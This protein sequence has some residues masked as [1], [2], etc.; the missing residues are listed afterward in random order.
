MPGIVF[1]TA[2]LYGLADA[3]RSRLLME[4]AWR[5]GFRRFDT[6]PSY[7]GGRSEP[8]LGEFL[9]G[10]DGVEVVSTKVGLA[11]AVGSRPGLRTV[12]NV[13]KATL[14]AAVTRRLRR[15]AQAG[16][17]GRFAPAEVSASVEE[18][19]RRLGGRIDR[20]LLHEVQP[21]EITPA[22][23]ETLTSLLRRGDVGAVGVAT[24]NAL[25]PA[26]L[27]AGGE[28]FTVAHVAV[29]PL[30]EPVQLPGSVTTRV[31]HGLLGNGGEQ[32][33]RLQAVLD[34]D[35]EAA[36]LWREATAGTA[37]EGPRGLTGALLARGRRLDVTDL[38]VATTR[39]GNVASAHALAAG[40]E[41][42][43]DPVVQ[44]LAT[45]VSRAAGPT[46]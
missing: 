26:A 2:Q 34:T 18:S 7:G 39:P 21:A 15:S 25:T 22:L 23:V 40:V 32:R 24:Q 30:A 12:V 33:D 36:D 13:A 1:G 31:G 43:P 46:A 44:A 17:S 14:P 16:T 20:L 8:A 9:A 38:L 42:M 45:L 28:V 19:L 5:V 41:P 4:E 27:A 11:P 37:F 3:E 10:R 6:A 35:R 29:G